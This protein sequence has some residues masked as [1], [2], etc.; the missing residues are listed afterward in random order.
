MWTLCILF[1]LLLCHVTSPAPVIPAPWGSI[2]GIDME[3]RG[4]RKLSG[5]LGI[6]FARPPTGELRWQKPHPH[7]GP[8]E[9]KV[10]VAD[11][12]VPACPQDTAMLG[13]TAG[14]NEDCLTLDVYVPT[15]VTSPRPVMVFIHGG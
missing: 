3:G 13:V 15:T 5:Y 7:P 12:V 10:F 1:A 14:T 11:T 2:Q 8:G 9:G 6:P 4:G